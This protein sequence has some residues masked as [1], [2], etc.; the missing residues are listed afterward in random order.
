MVLFVPNC[1]L[2][3][4]QAFYLRFVCVGVGR[5]SLGSAAEHS[6]PNPKSASQFFVLRARW[7]A[8]LSLIVLG[9]SAIVLFDHWFPTLCCCCLRKS[10]SIGCCET[11]RGRRL[12][13]L[14]PK[15]T[16]SRHHASRPPDCLTPTDNHSE[17]PN[18]HAPTTAPV[19]C[20]RPTRLRAGT[21]HGKHGLAALCHAARRLVTRFVPR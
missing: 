20:Q 17:T 16:G 14:E 10:I 9:S 7:D 13:R 12:P 15:M 19:T 18:M 11:S 21:R 2:D 8:V 6:L 1:H 5:D 4:L 3:T